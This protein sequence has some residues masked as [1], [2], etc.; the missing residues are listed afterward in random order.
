MFG[1]RKIFAHE[2]KNYSFK[3]KTQNVSTDLTTESVHL[4]NSPFGAFQTSCAFQQ[5][6]KSICNFKFYET[7]F[8]RT[9]TTFD[10]HHV[11]Q[12]VTKKQEN[13]IEGWGSMV[14]VKCGF[15]LE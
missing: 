4:R 7:M 9:C 3:K 1:R 13:V 15:R 5:Y 10:F 8:N 14:S 2:K 11:E 12:T 6:K